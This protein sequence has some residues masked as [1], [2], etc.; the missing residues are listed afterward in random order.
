MLDEINLQTIKLM[1][2]FTLT[3]VYNGTAYSALVHEKYLTD[4]KQYRITVMNGDLEQLL[5]GNNIL[6]EK[7]GKLCPVNDA[8][9]ENKNLIKQIIN[10]LNKSLLSSAVY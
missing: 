1:K 10:S 9:E 7:D 8:K 6:I 3:F 4:G 2:M 5:F